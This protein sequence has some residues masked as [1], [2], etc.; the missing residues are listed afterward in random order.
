MAGEWDDSGEENVIRFVGGDLKDL[1]CVGDAGRSWADSVL[2]KGW[3]LLVGVTS[4]GEDVLAAIWN[5]LEIH[6]LKNTGNW[7]CIILKYRG[8]S[9]SND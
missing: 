1:L 8:S 9:L 5:K 7:L 6:T 2:G 4:G 3:K